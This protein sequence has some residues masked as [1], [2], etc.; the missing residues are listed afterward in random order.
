MLSGNELEKLLKDA[1]VTHCRISHAQLKTL[2]TFNLAQNPSL[3]INSGI[4]YRTV[5]IKNSKMCG[6][7]DKR[8][9]K[10]VLL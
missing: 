3:T 10:D 1:I 5:V 7:D 6:F 4:I 2:D 9:G 8:K